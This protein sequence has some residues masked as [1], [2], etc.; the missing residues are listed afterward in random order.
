MSLYEC[1]ITIY[2]IVF[3][4]DLQN[5]EN[6]FA[7]PCTHFFAFSIV[8][9]SPAAHSVRYFNYEEMEILFYIYLSNLTF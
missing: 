9:S 1:W 3:I 8:N 7:T 6:L 5:Y 2:D 4:A